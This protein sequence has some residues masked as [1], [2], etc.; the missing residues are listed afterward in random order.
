MKLPRWFHQLGSPPYVYSLAGTLAPWFAVPGIALMI[1]GAW[2]GLFVA[3]ADAVQGDSYRIIYVHVPSAY[4]GMMGYVI[5]A[6]AAG[7][8]FIWRMKLAHAVAVSVAPIGAW[9]TAVALITGV[10]WARPTW[11]PA[12]TTSS[13]MWLDPRVLSEL[14]ALF[15]YLGYLLLRAAFA[16]DREKADRTSAILAVVGVVNIPIIHFSVQWNSLHQGP[17]IGQLDRPSISWVMLQ[18]LLIMILG[19]TL[20]FFWILLKRLR[21]EVVARESS[22]RWLRETLQ[23]AGGGTA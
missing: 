12:S 5:M 15:L 9:F 8:G 14:L 23:T 17:T 21:A 18:P 19:F 16:D 7:I 10:L 11:G 20:A 4:L 13:S 2:L 22:A 3:P 6:V 1:I